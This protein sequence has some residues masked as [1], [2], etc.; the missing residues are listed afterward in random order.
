VHKW[1]ESLL[2]IVGSLLVRLSIDD[3]NRR[4]WN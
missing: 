4:H 3:F 2:L 1:E